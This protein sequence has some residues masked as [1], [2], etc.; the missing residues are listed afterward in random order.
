MPDEQIKTAECITAGQTACGLKLLNSIMPQKADDKQIFSLQEV[1]SSIQK[2]L[3]FRYTSSFWV[4][5]EMNKLNYY[6]HSGHCYPDLV[7]KLDGKVIAQMKSTLWKDDYNRINDHFLRLVKAPLKE[8]IKI[9]FC[10]KITFDAVHGLALR[11]VDIDP[12]FSLGELEREKQESISRLTGEGIFTRNKSLPFPLLPKRMAIISVQTSKGYA[13]FLKIIEGNPWGYKILH[14]LFPSLLQGD[15][16]VESIGAQLLRIRKLA[17]DFDVVAIIRGGGGDVGL[18]CFNDYELARQIALFPIPVI[19]G[20]GHATNE[21]VVEMVAYK[22]AITPTEL[23]DFLLQRYH[24][25][26]RPV[27]KAEEFLVTHVKRMIGDER[28]QLQH[29]VRIFRSVT[30]NVMIR[31][32]NDIKQQARDLFKQTNLTLLRQRQTHA[33]M[34]YKLRSISLALCS[35]R[36]QHL[37]ECYIMIRRD[38]SSMFKHARTSMENMVRTVSN[39]HPDNVLRRGY[40]ITRVN[41]KAITRIDEVKASDTLETILTDGN[42]ISHV[43]TIKSPNHE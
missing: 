39:M 22:N 28:R 29:S 16:A 9:L 7:E 15:R 10:A 35:R 2:T 19:T 30:D 4:K 31:S 42:I 40:T 37:R 14:V 6:P 38:L 41:G 3:A 8:G 1:T 12:V 24:N 23:A 33:D 13:D 36:K 17:D 32:N 18:S 26:A 43:Q 34:A 27:Q 11:I 25:F 5:A 21:T 20:I